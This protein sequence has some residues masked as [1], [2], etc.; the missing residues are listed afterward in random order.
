MKDLLIA[1]IILL[2]GLGV[3]AVVS[4][5][6]VG[7]AAQGRWED[8]VKAAEKEGE[9]TVYATNS[10]GDLQVIWDAFKKKFAGFVKESRTAVVVLS[11]SA[12]DVV[13]P[14]GMSI[15]ELLQR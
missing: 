13:D 3:P 15:L 12:E 10:V 6:E 7:R 2:A 5:G 4:G 9:V 14:L 11:N 8:I 1:W